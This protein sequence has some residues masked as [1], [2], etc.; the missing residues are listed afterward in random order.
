MEQGTKVSFLV[1]TSEGP[2]SIEALVLS[3][4]IEATTVVVSD[5]TKG[6]VTAYWSALNNIPFGLLKATTAGLSRKIP[7]SSIPCPKDLDLEELSKVVAE[8]E[9]PTSGSDAPAGS[10]EP[11]MKDL[12]KM[13]CTRR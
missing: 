1:Q 7:S 9:I 6:L 10:S 11:S 4:D 5:Q 2:K 3:S 13:T 12:M 8:S